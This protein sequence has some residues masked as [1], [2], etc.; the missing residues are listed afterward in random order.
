MNSACLR[1]SRLYSISSMDTATL[2]S[3][4]RKILRRLS[5]S[6]WWISEWRYCWRW[7]LPWMT[8][9]SGFRG[10]P[11]RLC[12]D[13]PEG[14]PESALHGVGTSRGSQTADPALGGVENP[15]YTEV[16][17]RSSNFSRFASSVRSGLNK[18]K[19]NRKCRKRL[20]DVNSLLR[21]FKARP[22][23]ETNP[24]R[25]VALLPES[26]RYSTSPCACGP[27]HQSPFLGTGK[28]PRI[29]AASLVRFMKTHITS[30]L[31]RTSTNYYTGLDD[32][33]EADRITE[34]SDIRRWVGDFFDRTS[35][36]LCT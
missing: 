23:E 27:P 34:F 20:P 17:E 30:V 31:S 21:T 25:I 7:C 22:V 11:F 9:L 26:P 2:E 19:S 35:L 12:C 6:R 5:C 36:P 28:R 8:M 15:A 24:E 29:S 16:E 10:V 1:N 4:R 18:P 3:M 13:C 14:C 32:G 33:I